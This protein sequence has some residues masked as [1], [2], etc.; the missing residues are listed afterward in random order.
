MA[1]LDDA[2][3]KQ[4]KEIL[5]EMQDNV[6]ILF[7]DKPGTQYGK[8]IA[9]LLDELNE[10]SE[11]LSIRKLD[12][13]AKNEIEKFKIDKF[14]AIVING[15]NKGLI[16]FFGI[17]SGYEFATLLEDLVMASKGESG[18]SKDIEDYVKNL[19]Q[20]VHLMV[21]V[22]PTCPYCPRSVRFAHQIAMLNENVIGDMIEAIEFPELSDKFHVSGVPH[23]VVNEKHEFVGAYPPEMAI[24]EIKKALQ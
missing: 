22:T 18:L 7:F 19:N 14:P 8:E 17:P 15:K 24:E 13:N 20:K 3:K 5:A 16:R 12:E 21:F 9:A 6:E 11:K 10:L 2:T 4:V 1:I 23:N